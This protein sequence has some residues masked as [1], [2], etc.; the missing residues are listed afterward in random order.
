MDKNLNIGPQDL[1]EPGKL[2][3]RQ[4]RKR[5]QEELSLPS[6]SINE[7]ATGLVLSDEDDTL[8]YDSSSTNTDDEF[9]PAKTSVKRICLET[10]AKTVVSGQEMKLQKGTVVVIT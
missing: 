9:L 2:Q 5:R 8:S 4:A 10:K 7:K 1:K 3:K 6:N